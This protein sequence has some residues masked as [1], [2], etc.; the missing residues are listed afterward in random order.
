[1][2]RRFRRRKAEEEMSPEEIEEKMGKLRGRIP[3]FILRDIRSSLEGKSITREKFGRIIETL[4]ERVDQTRIDKKIGN[5]AEELTRLS[6][7]VETL[8]N[9]TGTS[10]EATEEFPLSSMEEIE[11][12]TNDF[13]EKVDEG[14]SSNKELESVLTSRL[15]EIEKETFEEVPIEKLER[16]ER[17]VSNISSGIDD[18]S[19]DMCTIL[20]GLDIN[21][22]V[23]LGLKGKLT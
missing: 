20:G 7:G 2:F 19:G 18:L 9:I 12:K 10:E 5:M 16:L 6:K 3:S 22:L 4:L 11:I 21:E 14:V 13:S 17:E 1:M 23:V 8:R 15:D